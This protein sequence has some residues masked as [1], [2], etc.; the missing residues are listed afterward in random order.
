MTM[1]PKTSIS[2]WSIFKE[3]K[4]TPRQ[5]AERESVLCFLLRLRE[6][7]NLSDVTFG[8]DPP[9][10]IFH[11]QSGAIGVEL[12]DLN[13]KVFNAGGH[14]KREEFTKFDTKMAQTSSATESFS[15]DRV[16]LRESVEAFTDQVKRKCEK[17]K[18]WASKFYDRWL[19]IKAGGGCPLAILLRPQLKQ[20]TPAKED[21]LAAHVAKLTHALNASCQHIEPFSH[22]ILFRESGHSAECLAFT[23]SGVNPYNLPVPSVE[24]LEQAALVPDAILDLRAVP[25]TIV[26]KS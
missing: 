8:A 18:P 15:W 2:C 26:K 21:A 17:A 16:T 5:A 22:V 12:T 23:P 9:D 4:P 1:L 6:F 3:P 25:K 20:Q 7:V 14:K 19:L 10:L 13:P 24:I 11:H